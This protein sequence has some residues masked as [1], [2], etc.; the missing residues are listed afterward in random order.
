M[1]LIDRQHLFDA[2]KGM[3]CTPDL[4][5]ITGLRRSG[6]SK[7]LAAYMDYLRQE[8]TDANIIFVDFRLLEN[9]SLQEYH[10]LNTYVTERYKDG[11][12]NYVCGMTGADPC[13]GIIAY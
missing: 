6:K 12:N 7:L 4:K 8:D 11:V 5:I 13:G 1:K 9:E 10:A 3:R 2:L